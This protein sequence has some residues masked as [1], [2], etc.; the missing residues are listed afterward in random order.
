VPEGLDERIVL[1]RNELADARVLIVLDN[2]LDAAQVQPL[3]PGASTT[4]T[5]ITSRRRLAGLDGVQPLSLDVLDLDDAVELLRTMVGERVRADVPSTVEVAGLCGRLPLALRLAAARLQ[6]R[7][8]WTVADLA[9]RL[10]DTD[11]RLAELAVDGRTVAAAFTLSYQHLPEPTQRV[12][13]SVGLHPAGDFEARA[14]AALVDL[15]VAETEAALEE[16]VDAHLVEAPAAGRYRLH[17]LLREYAARLAGEPALA[18]RRLVEHYLHS[19]ANA[20]RHLE[21][22]ETRGVLNFAQ[23]A[24]S[25]RRFADAAAARD[26]LD[27]EITNIISA[28]ALA[29]EH[30]WH[31]EVCL[32]ARAVW[33]YLY[34]TGHAA[35]SLDVCQRAL[36]AA[37]ALGD[38]EL[39]AI[40]HN[41][42]AS[43]HFRLGRWSVAL[44]HVTATLQM[45][46]KE[47]FKR[48]ELAA[49][50]NMGVLLGKLGR[51]AD[52]IER[53]QRGLA[54]AE[55][56]GYREV[57]LKLHNQLGEAYMLIGRPLEALRE[58]RRALAI[59]R[60][61]DNLRDL[62]LPVGELGRVHLELGHL[63]V[64]TAMLR[65]ALEF[66]RRAANRYGAAETLSKLGAAYRMQGRFDDAIA[67]Q[68][69]AL[70][71]MIEL[72][73]LS[74]QC[75]V[76]NDLAATLLALGPEH[77]DEAFKLHEQALREAERIV[78][79]YEQ[80]RAL[81]GMARATG[82]EDY[83]ARAVAVFAELGIPSRLLG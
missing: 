70:Q 42:L 7:P 66:K 26:W 46:E 81:A 24:P 65:R 45:A 20:T 17:D 41:Y 79:P 13:R 28:V 5:L 39:Q 16:L 74:G 30:G 67:C 63:T 21:G 55:E 51:Y 64:G 37:V 38:V 22:E 19:T 75:I 59:A 62:A 69:A 8:T 72:A 15:G 50:S 32:L 40:S 23:L 58:H 77:A 80:G 47:D 34:L 14:A 36:G 10:R 73:D 35:I 57:E 83:Q 3:L 27:R 18:Q 6:H 25:A 78:D 60:Q 43:A 52:C 9:A 44:E 54:L 2:A 82:D 53:S 31:R 48:L 12:F 1:W 11:L 61:A 29:E 76:R 68:R 56:R 4:C 33:A 71:Q 49:Y